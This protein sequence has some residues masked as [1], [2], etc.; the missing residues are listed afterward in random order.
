MKRS[1]TYRPVLLQPLPDASTTHRV[2]IFVW[3]FWSLRKTGIPYVRRTDKINYTHPH[4][5]PLVYA[6]DGVAR[7]FS[8]GFVLDLSFRRLHIERGL[9]SWSMVSLVLFL[10]SDI[11]L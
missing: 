6:C 10:T 4:L 8:L 3:P 9:L 5:H 7:L 11:L 2:H 1:I